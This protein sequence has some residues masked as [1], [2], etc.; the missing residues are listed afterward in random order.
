MPE[1]EN[2]WNFYWEIRLQELQNLGKKE[3]VLASSKLIRKLAADSDRPVRLLEL[4]CGEGQII[5]T[6]VE[7]H[8]QVKSIHESVG[9]DYN[10]RSIET[11]RRRFPMM[12]FVDG[13]FTLAETLDPL[14]KFE[15]VMM[16]NAL[17]EVFSDSY[18]QDLKEVDVPA[19]KQNVLRALSGAV[20]KLADGGYLLL[21]DG[22]EMMG[23]IHRK[24]RLKFRTPQARE[25][26]TTFVREYHPFKITYRELGSP[27]RIELSQRDFTR[28]ITKSIFLGKGLWRT[29]RLESYQYFNQDEFMA[30]I[31]GVGLTVVEQRTLTVDEEKWNRQV[32]IESR[33]VGF[34]EEHIL[35][36]AQRKPAT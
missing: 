4:G 15:L 7:G 3:A 19:A 33:G 36:I 23:D 35:I 9:I 26:F 11:C 12:R 28:Y 6:L 27:S 18:S 10:P 20:E 31:D 29:E 21:F 14:G 34:P 16:V 13:D 32:Q 25:H 5:G 2:F 30:A 22:L 17:H 24:V 8:A 1:N